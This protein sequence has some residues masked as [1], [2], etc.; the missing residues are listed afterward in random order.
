MLFTR[1]NYVRPDDTGRLCI[2]KGAPELI[3][4]R[5]KTYYSE[6][7][8]LVP[9]H[10]IDAVQAEVDA[11]SRRG[12]RYTMKLLALKPSPFSSA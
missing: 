7:G 1:Y 3:L 11:A 4:P 8:N 5:C 9:L 10:S 12:I 6:D 2:I